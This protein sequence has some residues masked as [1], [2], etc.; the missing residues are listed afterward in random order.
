MIE[1]Q[2]IFRLY[3]ASYQSRYGKTMSFRHYKAMRSIEIC[4]T[5][6]IGG[7]IEKCDSCGK[8]RISYNSCRNRHCPKCQS[9][10]K[11]KWLEDRLEDFLP[12]NYFHVVFTVPDILNPLFLGNQKVVYN[13]LFRC[14]S[15]TLKE[16]SKDKNYI[17]AKIGFICVLHTWGQNLFLKKH[18]KYRYYFSF[19]TGFF[20]VYISRAA[21]RSITIKIIYAHL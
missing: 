8:E 12:V 6:V 13:I 14:V 20:T 3:G 10:K 19:N 1:L 7:H 4:R 2:D 17:G 9:L 11:E 5:S 16:L 15:E 18:S 21:I